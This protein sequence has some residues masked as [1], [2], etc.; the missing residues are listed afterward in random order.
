MT[1]PIL[2]RLDIDPSTR[3]DINNDRGIAAV[4]LPS[5]CEGI[6]YSI[7]LLLIRA[8]T[9]VRHMGQVLTAAAHFEQQ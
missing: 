7:W 3:Y 2:A 1:N 9:G 5:L 8:V 4:F 6:A